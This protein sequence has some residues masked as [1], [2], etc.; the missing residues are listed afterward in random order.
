[1]LGTIFQHKIE[2]SS[3]S[4]AIL[5][6]ESRKRK[7]AKIQ[8]VLEQVTDFSKASVL[9]IGTGSGH[10]A[11]ELAKSAKKVSS[12]DVV[13]ERKEK[14][15]YT[16]KLASDETLP[17]KDEE[18]DIAITNHVVEH[19]PNQKKHLKEV[20]RVLKPGGYVYL[21]TPNKF[22]L[23]DPHYK[24][25]FIS[26][27]PRRLSA[28]YLNLTQKA[29]WD[30]YPLS[31]WGVKTHLKGHDISNALP[32]LLR[33]EASRKLDMWKPAVQVARFVPKPLL[34][35]TDL[36]SPTLIY[37]IQKADD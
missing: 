6:G 4:H 18:F 29:A 9:D 15:G 31:T 5:E 16:F 10:I 8:A 2:R 28:A 36:F 12:V 14:A 35:R 17:F 3:S 11:H 7:A 24:L 30:I 34:D 19:T 13:D 22:W 21:A 32:I 25:P 27:L 1:M 37:V 23:T 26:W 33:T 20:L